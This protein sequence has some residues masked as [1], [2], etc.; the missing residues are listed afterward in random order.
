MALRF[1]KKTF[2]TFIS[3]SD[4]LPLLTTSDPDGAGGG[5]FARHLEGLLPAMIFMLME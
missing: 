4:R 2:V 3:G 1:G 5:L